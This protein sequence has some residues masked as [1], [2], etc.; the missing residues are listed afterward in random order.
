[1]NPAE[2]DSNGNMATTTPASGPDDPR[3]IQALEE[4]FEILKMG[5]KPDRREFEARYPEIAD[6]LGECLEGLDFVQA[7]APQLEPSPL[8]D[9]AGDFSLGRDLYPEGPLGDYRIVRE[10]GRGGMGVVY[11]ALQ[12]S[13][14]RRVALKVLPFASA[15]DNKQLQ[16]F[17]NEAQAAAHLHHQNIVPVYAVGNDRGIHYYAMQFIDGRT[18]GT[19]IRE[20]RQHAG[21][22]ARDDNHRTHDYPGVPGNE[23][24]GSYLAEIGQTTTREQRVEQRV[25]Q[26]DDAAT[27]PVMAAS[28]ERSAKGAAFFQT[29]AQLGMQ[30]AEAIEHAHQLGVVHRDIK[31]ANLLI[32][33]RGNLW[34]TDFGLAHC[35]NQ[36]GLT[37]S[38]DLVG[39]LRYMSPEQALA[40]RV[41]I[42]H[43]TDI[44]SLG[45]TLYELLTLEPVFAGAERQEL[46]RQIAFEEPRRPR[47]VNP[48]IPVELETIVLKAL[49]KNPAD[50]YASAQEVADDLQRYLNDEP[51]RARRPSFMQRMR[52]WGR[53]HR[54]VVWSGTI[55]AMIL[56]AMAI[57][58]LAINNVLVTREKNEKIEALDHAL[59]EKREKELA[60]IAKEVALGDAVREKKRADESLLLVTHERNEKTTALNVAIRE[61]LRADE[62]LAKA[63]QV[64]KQY[65]V[66][67]TQNPRLRA[68][69]LSSLRKELLATAIPFYEEFV[70]QAQDDQ[71]LEAER[72]RAFGELALV[73]QETG[74]PRRALADTEQRL[75]IY[76]RLAA[77]YPKDPRY[78]HEVANTHRNLG[79]MHLELA[80]H[81]RSEQSY[82]E[83]RKLLEPLLAQYDGFPQYLDDLGACYVNLS[84]LL[85]N[86]GRPLE[87]LKYGEKG[88]ELAE[89]LAPGN[90]ARPEYRFKLAQSYLNLAS[91]LNAAA[92]YQEGV[93][94]A[95]HG[96]SLLEEL[97]TDFSDDAEYR[98]GWA[99]SLNN[100]G[101]MLCQLD[102]YPEAISL[103]RKGLQIHR[104]LAEDYPSLPTHRQDLA[105]SLTNLGI[106]LSEVGQ[107][108]EGLAM[109]DEAAAI[110]EK[111]VK[112]FPG[113]ADYRKRL[114]LM[115]T[116]RGHLLLLLHRLDEALSANRAAVALQEELVKS[117]PKVTLW[118]QDLG[119]SYNNQGE[120]LRRHLRYQDAL[121]VCRQGLEV[122]QQLA[123]DFPND[124]TFNL[125]VAGSHGT[126]GNILSDSGKH[127]E[128]LTWY[129]KAFE[130]IDAVRKEHPRLALVRQFA[131]GIH[132]GRA[133]TLR[134]LGRNEEAAKD[135]DRMRQLK[136]PGTTQPDFKVPEPKTEPAKIASTPL[137]VGTPLKGSLA[138]QDPVDLSP[139]TRRGY[140]KVHTIELEADQP[141]LIDLQGN[142]DTWMR[143]ENSK[144]K[145]LLFNDDVSP[146][147]NEKASDL[148]SRMVFISP[149][150]ATYRLVVT[151]YNPDTIGNY[152]L[153][154]RK[155]APVG[156]PT[157]IKDELQKN[158][159]QNKEGKFYK[160]HTVK[161]T[162]GV[163]Y[164]IELESA[165]FDTFLAL[166]NS[167]A[168]VGLG[169]NAGTA[170][171][172]PRLSRIDFTPRAD[173]TYVLAA[174]SAAPNATGAY[175]VT[176]RKYEVLKENKRE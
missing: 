24:T 114:G 22:E 69:D 37:M 1:M 98:E 60:L 116:N 90:A 43:R 38:G 137:V 122:R 67:T 65:L 121:K 61:K 83:A 23:P 5:Q 39:T 41:N 148:N 16:R 48:A 101:I 143:L 119:R 62:N 165:A 30:A 131:Y 103:Q 63:R 120:L 154:V 110:Q 6:V 107:P 145:T 153:N 91:L 59:R 136:G 8:G 21:L 2:H 124:A 96:A 36:A 26:L 56:V 155:A 3:V 87:A 94:A 25:G 125:E 158:D 161:L 172:T 123:R 173:G 15:L 109:Q 126:H 169:H 32:D 73:R 45:A 40:Q 27:P 152:T 50:R 146:G 9:N 55:A 171:G 115:Q 82:H 93:N 53:R 20:L 84:T 127:E 11:E 132:L 104:Q 105:M 71:D 175:T 10:V 81:A 44:Y 89:R 85:R 29:V 80:Q 164:T 168:N 13:L 7:A 151:S 166:L 118:R 129:D 70:K 147:P 4:Y 139:L 135:E 74:D 108:Q 133:V 170:Q 102:Q 18:L 176:V 77:A 46:L 149:H 57:V 95:R 142:F 49:E 99:D 86:V 112:A 31:P 28:T 140:F 138:R 111:L 68:A 76:Q 128:A 78:R 12:T 79:N 167:E 66:K 42:D 134:R 33:L 174:F 52:K 51:I 117:N 34:V 141:Y 47:Q 160:L 17:K 159:K 162:G 92:R 35:Q 19:M 106:V 97:V 14:N 88:L 58:G 150:K 130:K 157:L 113:V 100:L 144:E 163:S 54:A 72:A 156:E 64:V 75:A